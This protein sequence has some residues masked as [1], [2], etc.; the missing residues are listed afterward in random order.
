MAENSTWRATNK[1][2]NASWWRAAAANRLPFGGEVKDRRYILQEATISSTNRITMHDG[3]GGDLGAIRQ[4]AA[5][6]L[7]TDWWSWISGRKRACQQELP[8]RHVASFAGLQSAE[9]SW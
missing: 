6:N 9:T 8:L 2:L 5:H 7:R 3:E 1:I 4:S